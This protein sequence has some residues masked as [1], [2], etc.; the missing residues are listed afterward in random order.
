MF[1]VIMP[2]IGQLN[3][4]NKQ[5]FNKTY[6]NIC[7]ANSFQFNAAARLSLIYDLVTIDWLY[8][9]IVEKPHLSFKEY[10]CI[11]FHKPSTKKSIAPHLSKLSSL[12]CFMMGV[13]LS[14]NAQDEPTKKNRFL[15]RAYQGTMKKA[16]SV[17]SDSGLLKPLEQLVVKSQ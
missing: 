6:C 2:A 5:A 3:S 14:D 17:L 8:S 9:D 16:K 13:K 15:N 7:A 1:G 12:S 11:K 4:N 10:N